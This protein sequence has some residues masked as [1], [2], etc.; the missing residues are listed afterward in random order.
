[1]FFGGGASIDYNSRPQIDFDGKWIKPFVEFYD[2]EPYWEAWFLSS[3]TLTVNGTYTADAWGIGGGASL[4]GSGA[5]DATGRGWTTTAY[6]I[7]L[8]DTM[9]VTIGTGARSWGAAGGNTTLGTQLTANGGT[10]DLKGEGLPYRF[11][12]PDKAGEAGA[13][14]TQDAMT[15]APGGFLAVGEGG[16]QHWRAGLLTYPTLDGEGYG[17]SSGSAG[18]DRTTIGH[19]GA[20]VIRIKI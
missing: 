19:D 1:M 8:S 14:G 7:M 9:P 11:G 12:D 5:D 6:G 15:R 4:Q 13:N 18:T 3:G 2:G 17:A 16:W 20:L 10:R